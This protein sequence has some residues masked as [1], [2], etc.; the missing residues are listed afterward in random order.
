MYYQPITFG[1]PVLP[2]AL[3]WHRFA[4]TSLPSPDDICEPGDGILLSS[5]KSYEVKEWSIAILLGR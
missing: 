3:Q 2:K 1:L 5:Q 4:D